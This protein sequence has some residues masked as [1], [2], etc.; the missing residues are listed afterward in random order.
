LSFPEPSA[1]GADDL[2][3]AATH[4]SRVVALALRASAGQMPEEAQFRPLV[5]RWSVPISAPSIGRPLIS[6]DIVVVALQAAGIVAYRGLDGTQVWKS[7]IEADRPIA[8]DDERVYAVAA[9][10]V[11]ALSLAEG[12]EL[13]QQQTGA[14]SAP[15]L[16]QS[17]WVIAIS[18]G[19]IAAYRSADGALLWRQSMGTVEHQPAIDGDVLYVPLLDRQVVALNL[20]T[21][22]TL[23]SR[24]LDGEPGEL[25]VVGGIVYLGARDK[26][27]YTLNAATGEIVW[28]R[29]VGAG[30]RGKPAVDDD[31]IYTV[32]L[33]NY[34]RAY[35]RGDGAVK[36][37]EGLKYRP[38]GGPVLLG[39]AVVVPGP[40]TTIPVF[41]RASGDQ[42]SEIKFAATL[43]GMSNVLFG[44]WNYPMFAVVTGDLQHPWTLSFLEPS[45]DPPPLSF[46][47]LTEL[48][49]TTIPIA[50]PE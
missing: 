31:R 17:G 10:R 16:V 29:R 44:P 34:L 26:N 42:V 21:G 7:S 19:S 20:Q 9:E 43:V 13:W 50:M 3:N 1:S 33:D 8:I 2:P 12:E 4:S 40:V 45:T 11:H 35:A 28:P 23:W 48:P 37:N 38:Q 47:E 39:D 30:P 27:F 14:L 22:E 49:G 41:R 36:W 6:G 46:V 18:P 32:A 15:L 5:D 25:L 24:L